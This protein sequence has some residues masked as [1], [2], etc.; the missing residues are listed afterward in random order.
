MSYGLTNDFS[1]LETKSSLSYGEKLFLTYGITGIR[2]EAEA[3][4]PALGELVLPYLRANRDRPTE[5]LLLETLLLLMSQ[6]E[7]GN[8]IH[9]GGISAW[10]TVKIEAKKLLQ[11][12]T[13][14]TLKEL[15]YSYDLMLIER[16]LS[17]GGAADLLSLGIFFAKLENLF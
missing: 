7:D 4:Y 8:I 10:R 14:G 6:V 9:R 11:A 2:G 5:L 17:P 1:A 3:G 16:H 12:S 15:M 13:E